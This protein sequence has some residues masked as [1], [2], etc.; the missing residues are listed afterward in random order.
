MASCW[1]QLSTIKAIV[2][3]A[4]LPLFGRPVFVFSAVA[5]SR[6]L[7]NELI[8][9]VDAHPVNLS[10]APPLLRSWW[11]ADSDVRG[12]TIHSTHMTHPSLLAV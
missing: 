6:G 1:Q 9:A 10:V 11:G 12:D 8:A 7:A 2:C 3:C 4:V 5:L